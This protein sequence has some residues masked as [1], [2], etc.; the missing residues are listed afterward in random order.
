MSEIIE[1]YYQQGK[2]PKILLDKKLK[3]LGANE[4]IAAEFESWIQS[5][6]YSTCNPISVEGYTAEKLASMSPY[7]D[8][9][10]AF[11]LLIE[12]KENPDKAKNRIA[13]GFKM[14]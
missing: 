6:K 4:D 2:L 10:G 9:E 1:K 8:G 7:L 14:K 11:M 13:E 3:Q 5:G 12:L